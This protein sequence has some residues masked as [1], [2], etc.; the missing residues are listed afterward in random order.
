MNH[1]ANANPV[2]KVKSPL[3]TLKLE[4]F[5]ADHPDSI[6]KNQVLDYASNGVP[7]GYE[8]PRYYR[9]SNNW[10]SA[11]KYSS[12]VSDSINKDLAKG[13]KAGPFEV[14]PFSTFVG[15]PMGAFL[16]KRS[17]N[18][19]RVIHDLSWPP[20][21]SVNDGISIDCSMNYINI[22]TIAQLV[23]ANGQ[24]SLMAKLDLE[25]AYKHIVVRP[26][27]WDLLGSTWKINSNKVYFVDTVLPFGLK[28]APKLFNLFADALEYSMKKQGCSIVTHY[29]DDFFTCG[30]RNSSI[31]GTNLNIMKQTCKDIGFSLQPTKV[32]GPTSVL[33][34]LGIVVDSDKMELK[35]SNE[36]LCETTNEL[37]KW[38]NKRVCTKRQLLSLIGKLSFVSQVV[39]PGRTFMRR[40]IDL[41]KRA[42]YLHH[43][44][45]LN[46]AAYE[47]IRWW[48]NCL[49]TWNGKSLFYEE[50]WSSSIDLHLWTD[51][52]DIGFGALF[53]DKWISVPFSGELEYC[54]GFTIAWR[55]LYSIVSASATWGPYLR[56]KRVL[57]HCDNEAVVQIIQKGS[58]RDADMMNLVRKLF[59]ICVSNNFECSAVHIPG[60][61]NEAADA[62]SRLE[63]DRFR[64]IRA[65]AD[66]NP[67]QAVIV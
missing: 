50:Y 51:A 3:N 38:Q 4:Q 45:R 8:G 6:F 15:S 49:S 16:K 57:F 13:R 39:R 34:Y 31:C 1:L 18:K 47:D 53:G 55:E 41:S 21:Q 40:L 66:S 67:S 33:E 64:S 42:R 24:N 60:V 62:L 22:D 44:L 10:P 5:L 17:N 2:I 29:L 30:P 48:K 32:I 14:P 19:Y 56:S 46:R 11:I 12:A 65:S 43:R 52:S 28:S 20:G 63:L 35:I 7:I 36:R 61:R 59:Y 58:S 9:E 26:A 37:S 27:D 23:K 54:K 25:D